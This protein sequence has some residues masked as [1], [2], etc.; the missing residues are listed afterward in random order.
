MTRKNELP[1]SCLWLCKRFIAALQTLRITPSQSSTFIQTHCPRFAAV[2]EAQRY[3]VQRWVPEGQRSVTWDAQFFP[4]QALR[5]NGQ[6]LGFDFLRNLVPGEVQTY[7]DYFP[8]PYGPDGSHGPLSTFPTFAFMLQ[9]ELPS[10]TSP[11]I[12]LHVLTKGLREF[13]QSPQ[14]FADPPSSRPRRLVTL[15]HSETNLSDYIA[16]LLA[17]NTFLEAAQTPYCNGR[18]LWR[19]VV[20]VPLTG[21]FQV[22]RWDRAWDQDTGQPVHDRLLVMTSMHHDVFPIDPHASDNTLA[23]FRRQL[24]GACM[25]STE[26]TPYPGAGTVLLAMSKTKEFFDLDCFYLS[27]LYTFFL[28]MVEDINSPDTAAV[29]RSMAR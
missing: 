7:S 27:M 4:R 22:F 8:A 23:E 16:A 15:V 28:A 11:H 3:A 10:H 29:Q 21:N 9:S 13:N 26:L 20:P 14:F 17:S 19:R 18:L 6:L 5:E 25:S 1:I 24:G 12:D 2:A